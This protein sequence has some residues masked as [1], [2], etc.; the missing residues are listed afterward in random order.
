MLLAGK[1]YCL[2]VNRLSDFGLYLI[3]EEG[4]E[5]LLPNRFV[6]LS[7][8]IGDMVD[9]FVYHDSEDRIVAS[10]EEPLAQLGE[11][12]FLRA[13]DKSVHGVF[14]DWGIAA[15]N[16]FV[17]NANQKV[18]MVIGRS[19]VVYL[20]TDKMTSRAVA[21]AKFN[22]FVN[23]DEISVKIGEKVH[24]L[25]AQRNDFGFR[26]VI[27]NAHWGMIYHNQIFE[28][29]NIGDTREAYVSKISEDNRID[30]SLQKRGYQGVKDSSQDLIAIIDAAGGELPINDDSA[31][32]KIAEL[33]QM[34][35]KA[36]KRSVGVLL[37]AGKV[38]ITPEGIR[39]K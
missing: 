37:K 24:I 9:V 28:P 16:I 20:Y 10:T 26:V 17:P 3:D 11:V 21:T 31:P 32:E 22:K 23:N 33:T 36:F 18:D 35:K 6:S 30:I 13:V 2:K 19:Y 27:N 38:E 39:L 1:K 7:N 25:V 8:K 14:L 4:C 34:S 29:I 5:V 15:K 12:A